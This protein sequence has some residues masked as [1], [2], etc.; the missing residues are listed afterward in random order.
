MAVSLSH[1]NLP[2]RDRD[3][4][5]FALVSFLRNRHACRIFVCGIGL[6]EPMFSVD[7]QARDQIGRRLSNTI[8][9]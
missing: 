2:E 1:R 6:D 3:E 4:N 5:A 7:A 9:R 8:D